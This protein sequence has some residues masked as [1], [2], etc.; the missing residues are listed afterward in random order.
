MLVAR[1]TLAFHNFITEMTLLQEFGWNEFHQNNY[2]Q[3]AAP[4]QLPGRVTSVKGFKYI[5]ITEKGELETELAGK[6][7]Y[8]ADAEELPRVGDW[9]C[10]L[11]YSDTGLIVSV[12]PRVNALSRKNPGK[13]MERQIMSVNV[14]FALV[15]QGLDR[16]FNL[17]RLERY[18][19]QV[20]ACGIEPII[21]LNKSDLA[22]DQNAIRN[23][24]L[25]LKRDC[26][27]FFCSTVTGNGIDQ[28]KDSLKQAKT[29]ILVGSSGVGKS[30][31]L[32]MLTGTAA[33]DIK[34]LSDFNNKGRH[35]TTSR[36][37]FKLPNGSLVIDS[38]GMREF[39]FT[40]EDGQ[41]AES[42]F[43]VIEELAAGCHYADCLHINEPG[44]AVLAALEKEELNPTTYESY[45]KMLKEQQRFEIKIEDRKRLGKLA[46]RM[47]REANNYRKKHKN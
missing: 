46:G 24:V 10:Y 20:T 2:S 32:N 42:L 33:Q 26:Q 15:V 31:L 37:L 12:L 4:D 47:A 39:G 36:E 22:T 3:A 23:E 40:S 21:V 35:T 19:A 8:A 27:I 1:V 29:Y 16:D 6:L 13:R 45:I 17:M 18:I 38:P 9:V 34:S 5:L 28:L 41:D 14:D 7:L 25:A 11:D 43:P 44:C 30:S